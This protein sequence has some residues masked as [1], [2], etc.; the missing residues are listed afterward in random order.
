MRELFAGKRKTYWLLGGI[1]LAA[2]FV[3]FWHIDS[4]PAGLYPDEAVNGLDA[5]RANAT[6]EYK[7][8]YE[9]NYGREGLFINLQALSILAFGNTILGLKFWPALM[10]V[11]TVW[12]TFLLGRELFRSDRAGLVSAFLVAFSYWAINFSRIGFRANMVPLILVWSF[13]LLWKG[14]HTRKYAPFIFGGLIFGLGVH[15]YIAFR[16]A[17][18]VLIVLLVALLFSQKDFLRTYWKHALVFFA[19]LIV[20]SLPMMLDFFVFHPEHYTSRTGAISVLNP[21]V[22]QGDLVGTITKTLSLSLAKYVVW[23]DQNWRHNYPPYPILNPLVGAAF[24]L[25]LAASFAKFFQLLYL[26]LVRG[27][28]D[29]R[30]AVYAFLLCW[31]FTLLIPEFLANEGNPHALR[32]IGTIPVVMLISALPLLWL[33]GH[34]KQFGKGFGIAAASMLVVFFA[35]VSLFD[36]TKYLF[37]FA[38][39][40]RQHAAFEA[41]LRLASDYLRT[42]PASTPKFVVSGNMQRIPLKFFNPQMPNISYLGHGDISQINSAANSPLVILFTERSERE[43]A[44]LTKRIPDLKFEEHRNGFGDV[45]YTLTR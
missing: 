12:G 3:R 28:R 29:E 41:N 43:Y 44:E 38:N 11:L 25:G 2:L 26:R 15:T 32:A 20:T 40:P 21:E 39:N 34:I 9:D 5:Q 7:L 6:G 31:L 8:F 10:G 36:T 27:I 30:L 35:F 18:L 16:V 4:I 1:L 45:F 22:N 37:F 23:G 17:P 19:S 14:I 13:Y 33:I 24:A 42:I